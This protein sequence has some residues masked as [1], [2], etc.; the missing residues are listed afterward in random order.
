[1]LADFDAG[2]VSQAHGGTAFVA[3][4]HD[5]FKFG[6]VG[7]LAGDVDNGGEGLAGQGG[8]GAEAAGRDLPV[9]C[10][11]GA[12]DVIGGEI[13]AAQFFRVEPNAH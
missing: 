5:V 7:E 2:N 1:M 3:F 9:L 10:G 6:D 4:H 8:Q 13:I 12:G 11:D